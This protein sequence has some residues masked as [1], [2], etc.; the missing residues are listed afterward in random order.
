MTPQ[1]FDVK[2]VPLRGSNL[3]EASAGTGKTFS[4]AV[5]TLRLVL[6][7]V[8]INKLLLVTFTRAAVEELESRIRDFLRQAEQAS[9][10]QPIKEALIQEIVLRYQQDPQVGPLETQRRLSDAVR[11]LDETAILTIHAFCQ[12]TLSQYAV[13]TGEPFGAEAI[14]TEAERD[15]LIF[16]VNQWW[17]AHITTLPVAILRDLNAA[18]LS[19]AEFIESVKL[20]KAGKV[21]RRTF[22]LQQSD[23]VARLEQELAQLQQLVLDAEARIVDFFDSDPASRQAEMRGNKNAQ[24][25][26][27]SMMQQ[28]PFG[29]AMLDWI[30]GYIHKKALPAY[31]VATFPA[32]QLLVDDLIKAIE[33]STLGRFGSIQS[34]YEAGATWVVQAME[35]HKQAHCLISFDDMISRL[36]AAVA[37]PDTK[38]HHYLREDYRAVFID[39]FQD[40]DRAQYEIYQ[41][42]FGQGH[43]ILFYIGDPKQ[44]IYAFRKADIF[45]YL[46]ARQSVDQVYTMN[47][48]FRSTAPLIRALNKAFLPTPQFD[49]FHFGGVGSS[50]SIQYVEVEAAPKE[51]VP[52]LCFQAQP[53]LPVQVWEAKTQEAIVEAAGQTILQWL[54]QPDYQLLK[55]GEY[56]QLV[57]ADFGVLVRTGTQADAIKEWLTAHQIPAVTINDKTILSTTVAKEIMYVL[58]AV[59]DITVS[60]IRKAL[61]SSLV[62]FS[63]DDVLRIPEEGLLERFRSYQQ[64]WTKQGVYVMLMR[65][66]TDF[67]IR[68]R[69]IHQAAG[70]DDRTLSHIGQML[71]L[72]HKIEQ[73]RNYAAADLIHWLR[74]HL[75]QG[76]GD[77]DEFQLRL[78]KDEAAVN[79]VTIHKSKGLEYNVVIAPFL[80]FLP[81]SNS[82]MRSYRNPNEGQ[83]EAQLEGLLS[84]TEA[85]WWA[86]ESEQENRRIFYVALT[87]PKYACWI[88]SSSQKRSR[89]STLSYFMDAWQQSDVAAAGI[90]LNGEWTPI[91]LPNYR[92]PE[93]QYPAKYAEAKRFSL[94][95]PDWRS[96]SYSQWSNGIQSH[97]AVSTGVSEM[98]AYDRFVFDELPRG[99]RFGNFLHDVLEHVDFADPTDW[100]RQI[101]KALKRHVG[102]SWNSYIPQLQDLLHTLF[103][104]E[105]PDG[106][107]G[108]FSLCQI[109]R[110]EK[111]S[112]LEFYFPLSGVRLEQLRQ[113]SLVEYPFQILPQSSTAW[114]EGLMNG[115]IDLCFAWAG[116]YYVLDWKSNF[117][118]NT[119][120]DYDPMKLHEAMEHHNYFLQYHLYVLAW[121][122]YLQMRIPGFDYTTQFGG[123]YYLFVRGMRVGANT[124]VYFHKPDVAF[125][126]QLQRALL[127]GEAG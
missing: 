5:L 91:T 81:F 121:T 46:E 53:I 59:E 97:R 105:L 104:T 15:L 113:L 96:W 9:Q 42:L 10:G 79:I 109:K 57:P 107:G 73:R 50:N 28:A 102:E 24:R 118:G 94:L 32:A 44:S 16:N 101:E 63:I 14:T 37:G 71:E 89:R 93:E 54:T 29:Q 35:A 123:V 112:E 43:S 125:M 17:R 27:N 75:E 21:I 23:A 80:D 120:N 51:Q 48:N 72:L 22:D 122:K 70:P 4:I 77:D 41:R 30:C 58:E 60:R 68:H 20:I 64:V 38:L 116:R 83:Y 115:K 92:P 114:L 126:Q 124:G 100:E 45:T 25:Y 127:E 8:G 47:V 13:E 85:G 3:I 78:E 76:V 52:Q 55:D 111:I 99:T 90:Q 39:E 40:T 65:V 26:L 88:F 18:G 103:Q 11:L 117:L 36:H 12:R 98:D 87:R 62:A 69:L 108:Y 2:T 61:I 6:E 33:A 19:R 31:F 86:S 110:S 49:T 82:R 7:G 66:L 106:T 84:T 95:H 56:R 1:A 67:Q 74:K 34:L 119:L